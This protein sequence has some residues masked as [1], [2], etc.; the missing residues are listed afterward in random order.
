[1]HFSQR[2]ARKRLKNEIFGGG[3][4][5]GVRKQSV[6]NRQNTFFYKLNASYTHSLL[7]RMPNEYTVQIEGGIR[8][9]KT[10]PGYRQISSCFSDLTFLRG[11]CH[12]AQEKDDNHV[13]SQP[14]HPSGKPASPLLR[15][16]QLTVDSL[17][18]FCKYDKGTKDIWQEFQGQKGL[19]VLYPLLIIITRKTFH[20]IALKHLIICQCRIV[21]L[22]Q[23]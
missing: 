21:G 11:L 1:M 4:F 18:M 2:C 9:L 14:P 22:K 5:E 8:L 16:M 20:T 3:C 15:K 19:R 7:S 6:Q 10:L 23:Y 13:A 12:C 17:Q